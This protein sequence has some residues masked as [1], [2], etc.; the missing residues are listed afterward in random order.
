MRYRASAQQVL[1]AA[2]AARRHA[3]TAV[4]AR[5]AARM[6]LYADGLYRRAINGLRDHALADAAREEAPWLDI[7]A[8]DNAAHAVRRYTPRGVDPAD[9]AAAI[10]ADPIVVA[11]LE[12]RDDGR[13]CARCGSTF[14]PASPRAKYCTRRCTVAASNARRAARTAAGVTGYARVPTPADRRPGQR[15]NG[16]APRAKQGYGWTA[17]GARLAPEV[18]ARL[19][20]L[21]DGAN[22]VP[23][24]F[25]VTTAAPA[26]ADAADDDALNTST[27][28]MML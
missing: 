8:I 7:N 22:G 25:M 26:A 27:T 19:A 6:L 5:S 17:V 1:A 23:R 14:I 9:F 13:L 15:F 16:A 18:A 20:A 3:Y 10:G 2:R 11:Y 24:G 28:M 21:A 4:D 12:R